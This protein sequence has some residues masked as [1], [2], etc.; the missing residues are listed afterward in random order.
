MGRFGGTAV[1]APTVA[2]LGLPLRIVG[3]TA[4]AH[5]V[6]PDQGADGLTYCGAAIDWDYRI[7]WEA[8]EALPVCADCWRLVPDEFRPVGAG[9]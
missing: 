8:M 1:S 6:P 4:V 3:G 7:G 9:G 2:D 5:V